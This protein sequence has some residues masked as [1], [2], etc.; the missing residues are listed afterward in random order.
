MGSD[1]PRWKVVVA[2]EMAAIARRT[3][4]ELEGAGFEVLGIAVD[5]FAALAL[6][7]KSSPDALVLDLQ[8]PLLD[9]LGVLAAVRRG[10]RPCVVVMM[11]VDLEPEIRRACYAAG[12]DRVLYKPTDARHI[13]EVVL[14]ALRVRTRPL[15]AAPSAGEPLERRGFASS[16][17]ARPISVVVLSEHATRRRRVELEVS[18]V[19]GVEV[20]SSGVDPAPEALRRCAEAGP[21]CVVLDVTGENAEELQLLATLR[22]ASGCVLIALADRG[23]QAAER[24]AAAGADHVLSIPEGLLAL[25][26]VVRAIRSQS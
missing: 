21:D 3:S 4:I 9:G 18:T 7:E 13:G 16:G 1:A 25:R 8:M 11:T 6:F 22:A 24:A 19:S 14:E 2:D 10:G 5:G 26:D 17:G 23:S 15:S 20:A 12:A